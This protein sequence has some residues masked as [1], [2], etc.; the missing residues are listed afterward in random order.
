MAEENNFKLSKADNMYIK[1][2]ILMAFRM[3]NVMSGKEFAA[4]GNASQAFV[5]EIEKG[6]KNIS[7]ELLFLIL[8][9]LGVSVEFFYNLMS[10]AVSL[11][12]AL[13]LHSDLS[14]EKKERYFM[15]E[16]LYIILDN[17]HDKTLR[18]GFLPIAKIR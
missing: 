5:S 13:K 16:I 8:G 15:Q 10:Y 11:Y 4:L 9:N 18:A 1:G 14:D 6:K 2:K 3:S 12:S 7:D 17:Y